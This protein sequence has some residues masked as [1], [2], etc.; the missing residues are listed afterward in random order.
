MK[1]KKVNYKRGQEYNCKNTK[2]CK[3]DPIRAELLKATL[4]KTLPII[5]KTM[6]TFQE[7]GVFASDWKRAIVRPLLKKIGLELIHSNYRSVSNLPF[8]SNVWSN[9]PWHS[10]MI[11][12]GRIIWCQ[13]TNLHTEKTTAVKLHS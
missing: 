10:S 6:N 5:A 2:S 3:S 1:I 8:L 9:V 4:G 13:T 11:I 7:E 12:A